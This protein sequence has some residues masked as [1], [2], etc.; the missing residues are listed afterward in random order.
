MV[1]P[2]KPLELTA[3]IKISI[4][5]GSTSEFDLLA[6]KPPRSIRANIYVML[7]DLNDGKIINEEK[8]CQF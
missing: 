3:D 2:Y 1:A 7:V 4:A 5:V 6:N 8:L